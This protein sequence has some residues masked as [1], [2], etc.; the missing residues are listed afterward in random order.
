MENFK[1]TVARLKK[2]LVA[3]R[4]PRWWLGEL[5]SM[6]PAGLR[7]T[8]LDAGSIALVELARREVIL[9]RLE[10]GK[11]RAVARLALDSLDPAGQRQAFLQGLDKVRPG[12]REVALTLPR[13]QVLRKTLALPLATAENLR[14]VLEF[15][16]E[17]HTPFNASQVHFGYRVIERDFDGKQLRLEFAAT[18]RAAVDEAV[19]SLVGWGGEVRAVVAEEMLAAGHLVNLL[20]VAQGRM[21]PSM[22]QGVNTWLAGLLMLLVLGA[23]ALP[24]VIKREAVTQLLPWVEKGRKA[25]EA[26][27]ALRHDLDARVE[28]HNYLLEKRQALPPVI[29]AL[30]ELTRVL[31]DDTWVQQLEIKGKELQIQGETASSSKL[32]S[33]FEQSRMFHDASFRSPLTKG[34]ATGAERYHLA[35][36]IRPLPAQPA[37]PPAPTPAAV[38]PVPAPADNASAP[39]AAEPKS[40]ENKNPVPAVEKKP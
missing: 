32:V 4:F 15:Q 9:K 6:V 19:K 12:L 25:A 7:Q 18:P 17:L 27:D 11:I 28:A 38:Q 8:G 22:L 20:P 14:Q 3:S 13:D 33:L 30:E 39:A 35:L 21:A 34:Q 37:T 29:I 36:Q 5:A 24:V 16:M 2:R 1:E 10:N 40:P 31:P 26:A 23:M